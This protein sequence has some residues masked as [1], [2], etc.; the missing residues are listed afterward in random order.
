MGQSGRLTD[1]HKTSRGVTG[2]FG[3]DAKIHDSKV[4]RASSM[5]LDALRAKYPSLVFRRRG[6]ISKREINGVLQ[7]ID[8]DLG[9]TLFVQESKIK[10]DGGIIEV[11]DDLGNWRIILVSEAKYQG[12][13]IENIKAGKQVGKNGN[14]DLM[15]AGNA[16]ERAYKN[17]IEIGN[18][19]LAESHFPYVLFLEGAN[20]LT[21]SISVRRPDGRTVLLDCRSGTLNRLDR[22]TAA[23]YGMALNKNLCRN[24]FIKHDNET[25]MLQA[26]SIFTQGDGGHWDQNQM[27]DIMLDIANLS[28][29]ILASDLFRQLVENKE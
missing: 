2:I 17:I 11:M 19:M 23:N 9:R 18:C 15:V 8:G 29:K 16:I 26:A 13:D 1:Q 14:Q 22:L 21:E 4:G 24:K 6:S 10:P 28:I 20:F 3:D 7:K 12:K 27:A 25:I 5:V